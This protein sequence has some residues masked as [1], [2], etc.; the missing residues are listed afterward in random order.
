MIIETIYFNIA[1][2][3][4]LDAAVGAAATLAASTPVVG[5]RGFL[6]AL[7]EAVERSHIV[8]CVGKTDGDDGLIAIMTKGLGL[9]SEPA[10]ASAPGLA[11][12]AGV[13]LPKGSLPLIS[14]NRT[15]G[16]I[17]LESGDQSIIAVSSDSSVKGEIIEQY[18][19]PYLAAKIGGENEAAGEAAAAD[20]AE[21]SAIEPDIGQEPFEEDTARGEETVG[22]ASADSN[23]TAES[24]TSKNNDVLGAMMQEDRENGI[25][26]DEIPTKIRRKFN[27]RLFFVCVGIALAV[28]AAGCFTG[29]HVWWIPENCDRIYSDIRSEY[30]QVGNTA[31]LPTNIQTKFGSLYHLNQDI[32][33]WLR[34]D[35]TGIDYPVVSS[36]ARGEEY[37]QKHLFNGTE[38][39]YG[40]PYINGEYDVYTFRRNMV[41]YGRN[42]G[43]G[44]MFGG[45][46]NYTDLEFY[47]TIQPLRWI[48]FI[49]PKN[50][51]YSALSLPT[52]TGRSLITPLSC[53]R[54][55]K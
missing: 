38:S 28:I 19:L 13:M 50:G 23:P 11:D 26:I 4:T 47:K 9:E 12:D 22:A 21:H 35:G 24:Q 33:G 2:D 43:D 1:A 52:A 7:S 20:A 6:V 31:D 15:V 39:K 55:T 41:I 3:P 51:K 25:E 10:E 14:E 44:R 8:I 30:G 29:Y 49:T 37:Y 27:P 46:E 34:I 45:L 53:Q 54:Q 17:I 32:T 16:G 42:Y 40:T 5:R 18:V 48:R 36:A